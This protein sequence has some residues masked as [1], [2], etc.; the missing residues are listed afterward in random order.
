VTHDKYD[1]TLGLLVDGLA[2]QEPEPA[3]RA[4]LL[5]ALHG[6][7]RWTP[8][9]ASVAALLGIDEQDTRD[10][11]Q[12]IEERAAWQAG[13][14]PG[15]YILQTAALRAARALIARLPPATRIARH[16][17]SARELTYVLAGELRE[18]DR[19]SYGPGAL[20]D[21]QVGSEH[22]LAVAGTDECLVVFF[23]PA[24]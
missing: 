4:R 12:Q 2:P 9:A 15:S 16:N 8:W 23:L 3:A 10:A 11:L 7:E 6:P 5:A 17:H 20:V 24:A 22:E 21:M 18:D 1:E 14:W 19:R 13:L